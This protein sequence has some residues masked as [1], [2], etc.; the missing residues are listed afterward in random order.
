MLLR[1]VI[2]A[3]SNRTWKEVDFAT[4]VPS[5]KQL[6][7]RRGVG[8]GGASSLRGHLAGPHDIADGFLEVK[9][10]D[11]GRAS[12]PRTNEGRLDHFVEVMVIL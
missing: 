12:L 5:G 4:F 3:S 11:A 7:W 1:E 8:R 2:V 10:F 9:D 6:R